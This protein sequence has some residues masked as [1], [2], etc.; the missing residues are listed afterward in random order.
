[1]LRTEASRENG[2]Q[3]MQELQFGAEK[4]FEVMHGDGLNLRRLKQTKLNIDNGLVGAEILVEPVP[5]IDEPF[6]PYEGILEK[7]N[8]RRT[9]IATRTGAGIIVT[10][11]CHIG[12]DDANKIRQIP[13]IELFT[14]Q[15]YKF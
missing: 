14:E 2:L 13:R 11:F 15:P 8:P 10:K 5:G 12:L 4:A 3:W 6:E 9:V 7:Y 1:M